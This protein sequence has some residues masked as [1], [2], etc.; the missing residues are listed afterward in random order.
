[1]KHLPLK[2][3]ALAAALSL[4]CAGCAGAP[5]S[6]TPA[7]SAPA[8]SGGASSSAPA[9]DAPAPDTSVPAAPA[10]QA[11]EYRAMWVSYLEW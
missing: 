9:S 2:T 8:S 1:M 11:G 4:L 10:E 5:A 6:S 3:A 7:S